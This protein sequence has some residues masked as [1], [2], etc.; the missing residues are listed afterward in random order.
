MT[1]SRITLDANEPSILNT[2]IELTPCIVYEIQED[3]NTMHC[4]F[5]IES[6]IGEVYKEKIHGFNRYNVP[7]KQDLKEITLRVLRDVFF[8]S[9]KDDYVRD[10]VIR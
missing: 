9:V 7:T 2:P 1:E 6:N 8:N 3:L 5:I 10:S 4:F